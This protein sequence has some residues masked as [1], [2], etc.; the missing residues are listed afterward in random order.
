MANF[1]SS[2]GRFVITGA[3]DDLSIERKRAIMAGLRRSDEPFE[4]TFYEAMSVITGL[5]ASPT[6]VDRALEVLDRNTTTDTSGNLNVP[7]AEQIGEGGGRLEVPLAGEEVEQRNFEVE[8]ETDIV[9][10]LGAIGRGASPAAVG[11]ITGGIVGGPLGAGVGALSMLIAEGGINVANRLFGT[12]WSTPSELMNDVLTRAGVAIPNSDV[13]EVL[14]RG[15]RTASGTLGAGT[16]A[17]IVGGTAASPAANVPILRSIPGYQNL[18]GQFSTAAT[19]LSGTA[20]GGTG[21]LLGQTIAQGAASQLA[22]TLGVPAAAG[23]FT[24]ELGGLVGSNIAEARDSGAFGQV[25]WPLLG[26]IVGGIGGEGLLEASKRLFGP[27]RMRDARAVGR[28]SPYSRYEE[29]PPATMATNQRESFFEGL[30][31]G[32]GEYRWR[33]FNENQQEI[34][35]MLDDYDLIPDELGNMPDLA[36]PLMDDFVEVRGDRLRQYTDIRDDVIQR[37]TD[38]GA[39]VEVN[40]GVAVLDEFIERE[41]RLEAS[42]SSEIAQFWQTLKNDIT[43]AVTD[44]D[45]NIVEATGRTFEDLQIIRDRFASRLKQQDMPDSMQQDMREVYR[46]IFGGYEPDGTRIPGDIDD[47]IRLNGTADDLDA[48]LTANRE[49]HD[50]ATEFDSRAVSMILDEWTKSAD[51]IRPEQVL[52]ALFSR[53]ASTVRH[54]YADLSEE[55]QAT[56]RRALI[57]RLAVASGAGADMASLSPTGFAD[58]I[59]QYG[60]AIGIFFSDDA[61]DELIGMK[62]HFDMTRH[63]EAVVRYGRGY[64]GLPTSTLPGSGTLQ[65]MAVRN[66]PLT[67]GLGS[68]IGVVGLGRVGRM[69]DQSPTIR[70]LFR[71]LADLEPGS[72]SAARLSR[73][74]TNALEDALAEDMTDEELAQAE[75]ATDIQYR[76]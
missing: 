15:A 73:I 48:F 31:R 68:F 20:P 43:N 21:Q 9:G 49:L 67:A 29:T 74:I 54:L 11:A 61:V 27:T 4:G 34:L 71:E 53:D 12:N 26:S 35:D 22:P 32:S 8:G 56:A 72:E 60:D 40:R 28:R 3:P 13:E 33:R 36:V 62:M 51:N 16:V 38:N 23:E 7:L 57:S 46:A 37:L 30:R 76:R 25:A 52:D 5:P 65:S 66:N 42:G 24:S 64:Q 70:R 39:T 63:S 75:H 14:E 18:A 2:D 55:G 1:G 58:A 17:G 59:R 69:V 45:G 10:V 6:M 41:A 44:E 47:Y 50:M 19:G